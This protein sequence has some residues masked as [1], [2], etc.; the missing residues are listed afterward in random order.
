MTSVHAGAYEEIPPHLNG[1]YNHTNEEPL[2]E[3]SYPQLH[4]A[5]TD[6]PVP[7]SGDAEEQY[8]VYGVRWLILLIFSLL[9]ITNALLWIAFA[10]I[11]SLAMDY[12]SVSSAWINMLSVSFMALYLPGYLA[13][14][15]IMNK[16]NLRVGLIGAAALQTFG[17]WLRCAAVLG[18]QD[19]RAPSPR[20]FVLLMLGQCLA[21]L[22]QPMFTNSP[23]RL[24]ADWFPVR[25]RNLATTL[26]AMAN[27]IGIAVGQVLPAALVDDKGGMPL[28][29]LVSAGVSTA[30]LLLTML[31]VQAEPKTPPSRSTAERRAA[32]LAQHEASLTV[33]FWQSP[34]VCEL[35]DLCYNRHFW[36]LLV[37]VGIGLGLFNAVTTLVEQ[38][39]RP[40]GYSKDDA[41]TLGAVLIGAGLLAA[42]VVGP[43]MDKTQAYN[44][45]LKIGLLCAL[46]ATIFMLLSLRPNHF[47]LLCVSFGVLGAAMLPLLP[48]CMECAAECSYPVS[49]D[50]SSGL[51]L[52]AGNAVGIVMIASVGELIQ[53]PY[54]GVVNPAAILLSCFLLL[55][56]LVVA[57]GYHGPL[58]RQQAE[59]GRRRQEQGSEGGATEYSDTQATSP[60]EAAPAL[61]TAAPLGVASNPQEQPDAHLLI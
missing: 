44:R 14:F 25:Q 28:L 40:S 42:G 18:A 26:A 37:G 27:P 38:L 49:E 10:P 17:A 33:P 56:V 11:Q 31:C 43:V 34:L 39:V 4:N 21:A 48:V 9:T 61:S 30:T 6:S 46:G 29:L 32:K 3:R 52:F 2:V 1:R 60:S 55:A 13:A 59:A 20:G 47:L 57:V 24:S 12:F 19:N 15:F 41:G 45:I 36:V 35:K 7:L 22:A 50:A 51:M 8:T 5:R 23:A 54:K 16:Y 53:E 58:L